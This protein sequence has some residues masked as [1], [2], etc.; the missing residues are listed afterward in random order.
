MTTERTESLSGLS[1]ISVHYFRDLCVKS[2]AFPNRP[3]DL[4]QSF[5]WVSNTPLDF[6]FLFA[7]HNTVSIGGIESCPAPCQLR[8]S[9]LIERRYNLRLL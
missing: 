9:A 4:V 6:R 1:A 3:T 2:F 8:P 5:C 7:Y